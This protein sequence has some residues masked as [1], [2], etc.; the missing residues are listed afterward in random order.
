MKL[1]AVITA[2]HLMHKNTPILTF[3]TSVIEAVE[4]FGSHATDFA[5]VQASRDRLQGIVTEGNLTRIYLRFKTQPEK[6]ALIYYREMF[7]P[8]QLIHANEPFAEVVRKVVTAIGHRTFV[9]NDQSEVI[10]YITAKDILPHFAKENSNP[11]EGGA[12]HGALHSDLY[13]FE[14]FFTQSPFMMHSVN[15]DGIIQMANE[16]LHK[17]LGYDFGELIG[18]SVYDLYPTSTHSKV[19]ESLS[20]ILNKGFHK[21]VTGQ[22][23]TKKGEAIEVEMVSRALM[24]Q[25]D[26]PVGTMTV[27]RPIDMEYLLH[28]LPN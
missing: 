5:V 16:V 27:S 25:N 9:M 24:D 2:K 28:C 19:K 22:M 12:G 3:E 18:K 21:L 26:T 8:V 1:V 11:K 10:G 15:K 23:T 6:E 17:A 7:D 20:Q 4:Y 13:L 14:S